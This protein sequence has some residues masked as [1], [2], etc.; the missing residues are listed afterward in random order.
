MIFEAIAAIKIANE[1]IGAIKEFAGHV[2]SVGAMGKDLTKLADAKEELEKKAKDGD[3]ECFFELEKIKR[4][5]SEVKQM[6]IYNGR[7]GLWDDYCRFIANRKQM[8]ENERKRIAAKKARR[9]RLIKDWSI[10]IVATLGIL[11]VVGLASYLV[12]WLISF[13][14]K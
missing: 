8:K 10:G 14:G 9:K 3:M 1:A 5:E 4:H 6:F 7:P 13:K 11:S 2:E 12:Y